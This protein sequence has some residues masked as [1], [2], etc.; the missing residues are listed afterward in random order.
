MLP[1]IL[2]KREINWVET[3]ILQINDQ[4]RPYLSILKNNCEANSLH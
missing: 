2:R 4:T 1:E 3:G